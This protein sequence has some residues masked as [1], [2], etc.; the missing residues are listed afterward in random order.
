MEECIKNN[1]LREH[2]GNQST[3]EIF[4]KDIINTF[5]ILLS[6]SPK[7]LDDLNQ[8]NRDYH[9][10]VLPTML[11]LCFY[12]NFSQ[13]RKQLKYVNMLYSN[14]N[15][16][17]YSIGKYIVVSFKMSKDA[18]DWKNNMSPT[19]T[20]EFINPELFL[21]YNKWKKKYF[22]Y[23]LFDDFKIHSGFYN[24]F[25]NNDIVAKISKCIRKI[26]KKYKNPCIVYTGQ[27]RGGALSTLASFYIANLYPTLKFSIVTF[28][29]PALFNRNATLFYLFL[30]IQQ[31][32]L[33]NHYRV[34]NSNDQMI[35]LKTKS[36]IWRPFGRLRH[37]GTEIPKKY[38]KVVYDNRSVISNQ[39]VIIDNKYRI[40]KILKKCSYYYLLKIYHLYFLFSTNK[41]S[42]LFTT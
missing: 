14:L 31:K 34:I 18:S 2:L 17:V 7:K 24:Y 22:K 8:Y 1:K 9:R 37:I 13:K 21:K 6:T 41:N 29:S 15:M 10:G 27:S 16:F 38:I 23:N 40:D 42:I 30:K 25:Q 28:C 32:T 20:E 5:K 11:K 4:Q 35:H 39:F 33:V 12:A 26:Q 36:V 3:I 19:R